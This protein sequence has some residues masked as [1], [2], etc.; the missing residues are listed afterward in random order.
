MK[1]VFSNSQLSHVWANQSQD[2][3]RS[4]S[5]F[6]EENKIYSYGMHYLAAQIHTHKGVQYALVRS[7]TYSNA[8][9]GHLSAINDALTGLMPYF[10][11]PNVFNPKEAVKYLDE[12]S[13]SSI[14]TAL[15]RK[16]IESNDV[17]K[18]ALERI[19]DT[20]KEANEM[21]RLLGMAEKQPS[22][23]DLSAVKTHLEFRLKR[24]KELNTPAAIAK[25]AALVARQKELKAA[26]LLL[27]EKENIEKFRSGERINLGSLPYELLRIQG[28]E[29]V[30]SRGAAV[31]L[32]AAISMLKDIVNNK[33]L[34]NAA[35][36]SF[37]LNE[38]VEQPDGVKVI[39]IGCHRILLSEAIAV[40]GNKTTHLKVVA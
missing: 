7:D 40:L 33:S 16:R 14:A 34:E 1:N 32:R 2:S 19:K 12:Q 8:T 22:K 35:I 26:K 3:G 17:I 39:R 20:Y 24:Y 38:V 31:P 13:K 9:S 36:G 28:D 4:G 15:G 5:M 11:V 30:T 10:R 18:W 27:L 37:T 6:F 23:K 25:K 21:R 29:V